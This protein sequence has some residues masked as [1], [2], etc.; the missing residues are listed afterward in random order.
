[1]KYLL[2]ICILGLFSCT[3]NSDSS[4]IKKP[5]IQT[6]SHDYYQE[7]LD[8]CYENPDIDAYYKEIYDKEEMIEAEHDKMYS[9]T[10]N[11]STLDTDKNFFYFV[12]FTKAMNGAEGFFAEALGMTAVKFLQEDTFNFAEFFGSNVDK[13]T[14][15]D[16]DNWVSFV[17][18]GIHVTNSGNEEAALTELVDLINMKVL[19]STPEIKKVIE[20]FVKKLKSA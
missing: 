3:Q 10:E 19:Y 5:D 13:L 11:I 8:E 17:K 6:I 14:D 2:I 15:K 7:K 18:T 20:Q 1:M 16:M 12:V 9:I 4:T